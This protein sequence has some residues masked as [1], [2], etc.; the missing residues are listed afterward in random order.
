MP[1]GMNDIKRR[2]KSVTSTRQITKAMGLVATAKLK[3]SRERLDK[4]KPY[5]DT[6]LRSINEILEHSQD[7]RH[8]F[9]EKRE[10]NNSLY[11][12]ITA[13][14]GLA[15]GYNSNVCKL[16][17]NSIEDI[18]KAKLIILG[19]KG[20][21]F[22][23]N[24]GYSIVGE[25]A[26]VS[27]TPEYKYAR[28]IGEKAIQLYNDKEIDEIKLV[29][30]EFKSTLSYE[31]KLLQLLPA[32]FDSS[33]NH[34]ESDEE[35]YLDVMR[36]EPSAGEVLNYL[37]PKYINDVIYGAMIESSASEQGARRVAMDNASENAEE[38]IDSLQLL[39]NRARQATITQEISEIVGGSEALS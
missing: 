1:Q 12:I 8:P 4:S 14:R 9:L 38:M 33:D 32:K 37:I 6:I 17:Q 21:E 13:D 25:M 36:F 27:Q 24:K 30:T 15:G 19:S 39:Y 23:N 20:K 28:E 5:F 34:E 29:Y 35:D 3:K 31:P 18:N 16:L 2:I 10:V 26:G 22:F 7:V 11:I